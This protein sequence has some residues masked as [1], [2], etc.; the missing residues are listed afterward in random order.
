[1]K[2]GDIV[3][4]VPKSAEYPNYSDRDYWRIRYE[5]ING[6]FDWYDDYE[7]ISPIIK[8]LKLPKRSNILHIG[9]GNSEFSE[10]MYDEGYKKSYNI[11][12][13]RNVIHYMRQRNKK[14]RSS[15]IFETMNVLNLDYEDNQFDIVFDKA[16]FDCVLCGIDADKKAKIFMNEVYRVIRPKGYYFLVSNSEPENRLQYLQTSNLKYDIVV[17]TIMN[18]EEQIKIYKENDMN[19]NFMKKTHYIYIC[20]KMEEPEEEEEEEEED[21]EE[22]EKTE[23]SKKYKKNK[24]ND[25]EKDDNNVV[26]D[27]KNEKKSNNIKNNL[28]NNNENENNKEKKED[29]KNTEKSKAKSKNKKSYKSK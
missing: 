28:E 20:Q 16:V 24:E 18:D 13:S 15:M 25:K 10:K 23:K 29:D 22:E 17:H 9:I 5:D 27:E 14:L 7:T 3:P 12:F 1:M 8:E 26:N 6:P 21:E 11:D 4:F 19:M 2:I